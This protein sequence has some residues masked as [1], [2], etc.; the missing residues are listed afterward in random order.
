MLLQV[1]QMTG[2]QG[3]HGAVTVKCVGERKWCVVQWEGFNR[4]DFML[5]MYNTYVL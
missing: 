5:Y 2:Q 3:R 1:E 4:V